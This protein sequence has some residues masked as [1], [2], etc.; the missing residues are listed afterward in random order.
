MPSFSGDQRRK[1]GDL[2]VE[3]VGKSTYNACSA[4]SRSVSIWEAIRAI[5]KRVQRSVQRLPPGDWNA[6]VQE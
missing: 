2:Y 5:G 6:V 4:I 1:L 3:S